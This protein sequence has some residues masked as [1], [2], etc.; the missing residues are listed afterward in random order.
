MVKATLP[1]GES[2][3]SCL[4]FQIGETTQVHSGGTL[5]ATPHAVRATSQPGKKFFFLCS[6]CVLTVAVFLLVSRV[7]LTQNR[8]V[9]CCTCAVYRVFTI[10]FLRVLLFLSSCFAS[11]FVRQRCVLLHSC[12]FNFIAGIDCVCRISLVFVVV[13]IVV[14]G[15]R[16]FDCFVSSCARCGKHTSRWTIMRLDTTSR[17][18]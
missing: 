5:Q 16:L 11:F 10:A 12:R 3:S 13:N 9:Y 8:V 15:C 14:E 1:E 17:L 6:K 7:Y 4:L 18:E 2:L